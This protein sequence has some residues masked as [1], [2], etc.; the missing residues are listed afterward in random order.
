MRFS[1]ARVVLVV[2]ALGVVSA[3]AGDAGD[4]GGAS[5]TTVGASGTTAVEETPDTT[6]AADPGEDP[7]DGSGDGGFGTVCLE[8]TQAMAAAIN[9]YSTGMAGAMGGSRDDQSLQESAAQLQAMADAAPDEI[10]GDLD[11]IAN[12]LE[13]FYTALAES[14]YEPGVAPTPEQIAQLSALAEVI[15]QEAFD[16]ASDNINEWFE[17]NC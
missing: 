10:K 6:A 11:V 17:A 5:T 4:D 15:D 13:G 2:L 1:L 14:G 7:G 3:C 9:A 12:E 16:E 8:A